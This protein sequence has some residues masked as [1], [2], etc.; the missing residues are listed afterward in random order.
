MSTPATSTSID[1]NAARAELVKLARQD[2][3]TFCE[4]VIRDEST[5]QPIALA[6]MHEEQLRLTSAHAR[7]VLW[8]AIEHGK[9]SLHTVARVLW[10]LG[11]DPGKRIA[12]VSNTQHQAAKFVGAITRYIERSAELREVFPHLVPGKPWGADTITVARPNFSKDPSVQA[13]GVSG[14]VL[15]ARLD[16]IIADDVLDFEN[17]RTDD[18][19][20]RLID[21]TYSTLLGRLTHHGRVVLL[22]VA[23]HP[24]DL[25]HHLASNSWP[26]RRF[27]VEDESGQPRWPSRWPASRIA[28]KRT[29]LG[30]LEAARQLDCMARSDE[31]STFQVESV[32]AACERGRHRPLLSH[33][34]NV[35]PPSFVTIGVDLAVS[36]RS[37]ADLT[38]IAS[39]L[40]HG[41]GHRELI[42]ID[43]GRWDA[44]TIIR[45]IMAANEAYRPMTIVVESVAAQMYVTQLLRE[46]S[47]IPVKSFITG[48]NKMSLEWQARALSTE[49]SNGKWTLRA[50]TT[51]DVNALVR[52]ILYYDPRSHCGDRLVSLLLARWGAD[53]AG[54]RIEYPQIDFT[55]R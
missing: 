52:E 37:S 24:G 40:V 48:R 46:W 19:R 47:A 7:L 14:N 41:N 15:G 27:A 30:P 5:G 50:P 16:L 42:N 18:Q 35:P 20:K 13:I 8:A 23:H 21:W 45:R 25:M 4:F 54:L 6:P 38:A 11:R 44:P 9:S 17:T 32:V 29:E 3:A 36:N 10:E 55:R 49:M 31:S 33:V 1:A 51:P 2:L 12:I 22:G 28:A 53:Q 34:L 43:S 26:A 39:V